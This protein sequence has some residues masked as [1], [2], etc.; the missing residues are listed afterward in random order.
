MGLLRDTYIINDN[1]GLKD[2][3]RMSNYIAEEKFEF[4]KGKF[5]KELEIKNRVDI[6]L[7]EYEKL[8]EELKTTKENLSYY[9]NFFN[10]L[11]KSIKINPEV[12]LKSNIVKSEVERSYH[13]FNNYLHVIFELK[14]SDI[15]DR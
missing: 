14:D 7:T 13:S 10:E 8:K 12:L 15:N 2:A 5:E 6:A 4:E 9:R 11:V 3:I 1:K